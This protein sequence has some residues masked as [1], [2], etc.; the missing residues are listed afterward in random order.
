MVHLAQYGVQ[1]PGPRRSG[2]LQTIMVDRQRYCWRLA[3]RQL[4]LM[5]QVGSLRRLLRPRVR[6]ALLML[7]LV[8]PLDLLPLLLLVLLVLLLLHVQLLVV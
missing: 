6:L 1:R 2:L 5:V 8:L 7:L 3:L 4:A